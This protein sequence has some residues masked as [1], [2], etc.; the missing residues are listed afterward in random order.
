MSFVLSKFNYISPIKTVQ[1]YNK[2]RNKL[3]KKLAIAYAKTSNKNKNIVKK[4]AIYLWLAYLF[5]TTFGIILLIF[6]VY[7]FIKNGYYGRYDIFL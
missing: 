7:I 1:Y 6:F 3:I 5:V 4:R 2:N